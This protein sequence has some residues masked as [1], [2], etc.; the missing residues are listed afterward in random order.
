MGEGL[1][2]EQIA[3]YLADDIRVARSRLVN[4]VDGDEEIIDNLKP[5]QRYA[6][7]DLCV[8]AG[9]VKGTRLAKALKNMKME[10]VIKNYDFAGKQQPG[11]CLRRIQALEYMVEGCGKK[12]KLAALNKI[13]ELKTRGLASLSKKHRGWYL[14]E[15]NAVSERIRT[16]M[17][18]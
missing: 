4:A 3:A 9:G 6:L 10:D 14:T 11:I 5:G 16:S 18:S 15:I 2:N 12:E 8:N 1:S 7:T 13:S 17:T